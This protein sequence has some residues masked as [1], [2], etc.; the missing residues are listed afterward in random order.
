EFAG[1]A[2]SGASP[3][4]TGQDTCDDRT[5]RMSPVPEIAWDTIAEAEIEI[6]RDRRNRDRR[7]EIMKAEGDVVEPN[8]GNAVRRLYRDPDR[9]LIV[10]VAAGLA[11]HLGLKVAVVRA[12]FIVL[13]PL[14]GVGALLYVALWV[15]LPTRPV[16]PNPDPE[17]AAAE[18][19]PRRSRSITDL[20]PYAALGIG[21]LLIVSLA[22]LGSLTSWLGWAVAVIGVGAGL[23]WHLADA[24]RRRRWSRTVPN[25]PWLG[26]LLDEGDRRGYL[27]R[28]IGGAA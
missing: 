10:G 5:S 13:L 25:A 20:I 26:A 18:P 16:D 28:L 14:N 11:E 17:A 2:D 7:N 8:T 24:D 6:L 19:A 21:I 4:C 9:R 22:G 23:I 3:E 27:I 15:V 1:R 12:A